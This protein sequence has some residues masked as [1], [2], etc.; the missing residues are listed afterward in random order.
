MLQPFR[1]DVFREGLGLPFILRARRM[2]IPVDIDKSPI[3]NS[4]TKREW[5]EHMHKGLEGYQPNIRICR[6][7][8][9]YA[10]R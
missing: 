3:G 10:G 2:C 9:V 6:M 4:E 5:I 8:R 1:F 7:G